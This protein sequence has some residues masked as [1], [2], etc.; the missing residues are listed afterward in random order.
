M[1]M[2]VYSLYVVVCVHTVFDNCQHA[3]LPEA[4]TEQG[5]VNSGRP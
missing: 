2:P 5:S 4:N 1:C 3:G